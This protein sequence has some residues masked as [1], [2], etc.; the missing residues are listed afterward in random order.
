MTSRTARRGIIYILANQHMPGILKIGQTTRDTT[1]R[2]RELSRATGVPADFEVIY[3]EIVSDVDAAE[4]EIHSELSHL[5]INKA[6]EFFRIGIRD[7][8]KI[9]QR[10]AREFEVDESADA[11]E[12]EILPSIENRMRRWLRRE[13]VSVKFVQFPDLCL[14]RVTEQPDVRKIDAFQTAVDLRGFGGEETGEFVDDLGYGLLF[15]PYS[16]SIKENVEEFLRLDPYSMIM[17]GLGLLSEDAAN[18]V[19]YLWEKAR[20]EPPLNP[21]WRVSAIKYDMWGS[22]EDDDNK[23]LLLRLHEIDA[24]RL[25]DGKA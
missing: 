10:I 19:A 2:V 22:P 5:R 1:T 20:I 25:G 4:S 21:G 17:T 18:Y 11:V 23:H 12:V 8:I 3:D 7:A 6:R 24:Q 14:L 13:I 9:T 16:K 15:N